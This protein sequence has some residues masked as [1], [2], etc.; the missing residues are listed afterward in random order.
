MHNE[1]PEAEYLMEVRLFLVSNNYPKNS[2][3]PR[4]VQLNYVRD[5]GDSVRLRAVSECASAPSRS[6]DDVVREREHV[7]L[8]QAR[9]HDKI[10]VEPDEFALGKKKSEAQFLPHLSASLLAI[11]RCRAQRQIVSLTASATSDQVLYAVDVCKNKLLSKTGG[12]L[13]G[14]GPEGLKAIEHLERLGR[15]FVMFLGE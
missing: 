15:V 4:V 14:Q 1:H 5:R 11:V 10:D 9:P 12:G 13:R 3:G 8:L 2:P 6:I 7:T